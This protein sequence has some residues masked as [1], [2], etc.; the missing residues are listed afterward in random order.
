MNKSVRTDSNGNYSFSDI[1]SGYYNVTASLNS[2]KSQTKKVE[3]Q[4]T[5]VTLNFQLDRS[6]D[7]SMLFIIVGVVIAVIL[8]LLLLLFLLMKKRKE[9]EAKK[10]EERE[11]RGIKE[12]G[13]MRKPMPPPHG[14][15][16]AY[17]GPPTPQRPSEPFARQMM[18]PPSPPPPPAAH[19]GLGQKPS[20]AS[21]SLEA[22]EVELEEVS[23]AHPGL[24]QTKDGPRVCPRCFKNNDPWDTSCYWCG[25]PLK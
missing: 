2:Y 15:R 16:S 12:T 4:T 14:Y 5:T 10:K 17:A 7:N 18:S 23:E 8:V 20:S 21:G 13:M 9:Q 1:P 6:E 11:M 22:E 19:P 25:T 24:T 3:V